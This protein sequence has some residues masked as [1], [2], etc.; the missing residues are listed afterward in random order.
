MFGSFLCVWFSMLE[1]TGVC[2]NSEIFD[3]FD[4]VFGSVFF[5][6]HKG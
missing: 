6:L 4:G 2:I 3:G 5:F 1:E